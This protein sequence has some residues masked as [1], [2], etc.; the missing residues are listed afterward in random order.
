MNEKRVLTYIG[1]FG[2]AVA[3]TGLY[4][5]SWIVFP[6]FFPDISIPVYP[7]AGASVLLLLVGC[8]ATSGIG[9]R[10]A[11]LFVRYRSL[12]PSVI[13]ADL[14]IQLLAFSQFLTIGLLLFLLQTRM[15]GWSR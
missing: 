10:I 14:F 2:A 1:L 11:I 8:A 3:V 12:Q 5:F 7:L 4:F 15:P 6:R 13:P 9:I